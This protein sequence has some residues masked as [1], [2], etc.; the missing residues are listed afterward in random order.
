MVTDLYQNIQLVG[1]REICDCLRIF[2]LI[3]GRVNNQMLGKITS[4]WF[5]SLI[6]GGPLQRKR[7]LNTL[8]PGLNIIIKVGST[9]G[10]CKEN[11][12]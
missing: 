10:P 9:G 2:I 6:N 3:R 12:H 8:Q 1:A 11:D 5:G 4:S 7:S